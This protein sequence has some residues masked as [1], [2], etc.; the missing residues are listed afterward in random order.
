MWYDLNGNNSI[1]MKK[2]VVCEKKDKIIKKF[3]NFEEFKV[4]K[5]CHDTFCPAS[6]DFKGGILL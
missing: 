4:C 1:E 6:I 3:L 2:M 5:D